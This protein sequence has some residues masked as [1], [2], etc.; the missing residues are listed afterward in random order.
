MDLS[1]ISTNFRIDEYI[2]EK[3]K[4]LASKEKHSINSQMEYFL[5]KGVEAYEKTH[6][7][8]KIENIGG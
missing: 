8:I 3:T 6:G 4:I 1:K 2:Y 7:E 5:L